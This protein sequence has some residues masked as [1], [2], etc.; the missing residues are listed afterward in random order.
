MRSR[1][2]EVAQTCC[3][4][5]LFLTLRDQAIL[6][7]DSS[8][9]VTHN[10]KE[11]TFSLLQPKKATYLSMDQVCQPHLG[12]METS[13]RQDSAQNS[14]LNTLDEKLYWLEGQLRSCSNRGHSNVGAGLPWQRRTSMVVVDYQ[15]LQT[16]G[17]SRHRDFEDYIMRQYYQR[18]LFVAVLSRIKK[19]QP[20]VLANVHTLC[21]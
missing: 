21:V 10:Q 18:L 15:E 12:V 5:T 9:P 1:G 11:C 8:L 6:L 7:L 16:L 13:K 2:K 20:S 19:S 14:S 17:E 3:K 4:F